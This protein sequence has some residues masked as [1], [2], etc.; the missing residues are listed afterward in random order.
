MDQPHPLEHSHH[1]NWRQQQDQASLAPPKLPSSYQL[2]L[3]SLVASEEWPQEDADNEKPK[4][5]DDH[6]D[7][8]G[9]KEKPNFGFG[10][11]VTDN[12]QRYGGGKTI[13]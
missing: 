5:S 10:F 11:D 13:A 9:E 2:P 7:S 3:A 12:K 8:Q 1:S 4:L 6:D